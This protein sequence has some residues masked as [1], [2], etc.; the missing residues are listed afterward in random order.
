[1]LIIHGDAD[2]LVPVEHSAR[3]A[4]N[5]PDATV[6]IVPAATHVESWVRLQDA[7]VDRV[8]GFFRDGLR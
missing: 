8:A 3:L 5:A 7:Y 6:W 1:V 4:A 2:E